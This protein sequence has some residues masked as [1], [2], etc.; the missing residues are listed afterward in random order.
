MAKKSKELLR[1]EQYEY[2]R[3]H[4]QD[5]TLLQL[6][7]ENNLN[8]QMVDYMNNHGITTKAKLVRTAIKTMLKNG[9]GKNSIIV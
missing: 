9:N 8:E 6:Y 1:E 5:K 4:R 3:K 7:V 2:H